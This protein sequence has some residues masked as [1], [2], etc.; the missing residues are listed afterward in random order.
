MAF[1]H[2]QQSVVRQIF[3]QRGRRFAR[4]AAREVAA[5]IFNTFAGTRGFHH[6]NVKDGTLFQP[7]RFQ[8]FAFRMQLCQMFLQ[9]ILDARDGLGQ[10]RA[11]GDIVAIRVNRNTFH[12]RGDFARQRIEFADCLNLIAEKRNAPGAVFQMARP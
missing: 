3:E 9:F 5:V 6:F 4:I 1:I 8:Q 12:L 2:D 11:R 7:L 10:R